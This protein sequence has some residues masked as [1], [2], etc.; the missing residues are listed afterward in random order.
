M[1]TKTLRAVG[2]SVGKVVE[3][4]AGDQAAAMR[5]VGRGVIPSIGESDEG[6]LGEGVVLTGEG[7]HRVVPDAPTNLFPVRFAA[8]SGGEADVSS[9]FDNF[10]VQTAEPPKGVSDLSRVD[11]LPGILVGLLVLVAVATLAHTLV[12][13]VRL[14]RRDLAIL[15]TLGFQRRQVRATVAWQ[16]TAIVVAALVV[17]V[18]LGVAVG[19]WLWRLFSENLGIVP[20]PVVSLLAVLVVVP[21]GLAIA[22]LVAA[23]P[24]RAAAATRPAAALHTE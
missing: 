8:T 10:G 23:L 20:A 6:G 24:A 2:A 5:V 13:T 1:G 21:A 22:N 17:A 16:A 14:R 9:Q 4:K 18:P 11:G 3:V 15:K 19:R 7:L 12:T